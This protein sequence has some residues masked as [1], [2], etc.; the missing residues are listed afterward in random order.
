MRQHNIEI[1]WRVRG[2]RTPKVLKGH[3]DHVI[4]CL[5]FSNNRIVSGSDDNTLKVSKQFWRTTRVQKFN[6]TSPCL[7]LYKPTWLLI[8]CE[9]QGWTNLPNFE[10]FPGN[11]FKV[12]FSVKRLINNLQN[13]GFSKFPALWAAGAVRP[14]IYEM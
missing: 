7:F 2:I 13:K 9:G 4:T 6:H 1:N 10:Q 8:P 12:R 3:D 5:Q 14:T 11:F